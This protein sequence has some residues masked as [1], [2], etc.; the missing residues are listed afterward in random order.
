MRLSAGAPC[1]END[2]VCAGQT[3]KKNPSGGSDKDWFVLRFKRPGFTIG[4]APYVGERPVPLKY[5]PAI[6]S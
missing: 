2:T 1:F 3:A 5:F 6:W 4:V